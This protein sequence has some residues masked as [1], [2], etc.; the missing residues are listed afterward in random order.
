MSRR[1]GK[2]RGVRK[3]VRLGANGVKFVWKQHLSKRGNVYWRRTKYFIF[4]HGD[5]R[6]RA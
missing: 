3:R 6:R 2:E 1:R 4:E 5:Y